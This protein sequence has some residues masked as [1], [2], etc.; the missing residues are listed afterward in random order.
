[1]AEMNHI[2]ACDTAALPWEER[3]SEHPG[4][5]HP[6]YAY[7]CAWNVC[8]GRQLLTNAGSFGPGHFVCFPVKFDIT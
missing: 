4:K 3:R 5:M 7:L 8:F 6:V 1:V 2:P